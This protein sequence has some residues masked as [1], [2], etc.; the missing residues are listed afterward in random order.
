MTQQDFSEINNNKFTNLSEFSR[1][2]KVGFN[3]Y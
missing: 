2:Y 1:I 3:E